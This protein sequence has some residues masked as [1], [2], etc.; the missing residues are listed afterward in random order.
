MRISTQ[1]GFYPTSDRTTPTPPASTTSLPLSDSYESVSNESAS[2]ESYDKCTPARNALA[3]TLSSAASGV[4]T[5]LKSSALCLSNCVGAS[6]VVATSCAAA[7]GVLGGT[8]WLI[9]TYGP[10]APIGILLTGC[11]I[12]VLAR[13]RLEKSKNRLDKIARS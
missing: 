6:A 13:D 1:P 4:A 12:G 8:V 9:V 5:G 10:M 3:S 7:V 2:V 11:A